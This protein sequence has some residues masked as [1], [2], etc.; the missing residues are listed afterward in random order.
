MKSSRVF[1]GIFFILFGILLLADR[2]D[3]FSLDLG[4]IWRF[5]PVILILVGGSLLFRS[6]V[7]WVFLSLGAVCGAMILASVVGLLGG[8]GGVS[9]DRPGREQHLTIPRRP[10]IERASFRF[11]GGAGTLRIAEGEG[12]LARVE[13]RTSMGEYTLWHDSSA[14]RDEVSLTLEGSN[15]RWR[16]GR[17]ENHV[18][19]ML[20]PEPIWDLDLKLGAASVNLDLR[21]LAVERLAVECGASTFVIRLGDR[22]PE[23]EVEVIAGASS[24]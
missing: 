6:P 11:D 23:A 13:T 15:R 18:E 20:H 17:I 24:R 1:W 21:R 9:G 22:V 7:R 12:E 5:W 19:A 2:F 16:I 4:S 14:E 10:G 3:V 8:W